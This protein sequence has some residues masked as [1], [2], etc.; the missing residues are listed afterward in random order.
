MMIIPKVTRRR[1]F[2]PTL[3]EILP[4]GSLMRTLSRPIIET[5]EQKSE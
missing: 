1:A 5:R 3:S 4:A 2:L